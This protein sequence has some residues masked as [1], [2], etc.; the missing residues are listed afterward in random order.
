MTTMLEGFYS[1]C[2]LYSMLHKGR[3]KK[4][5]CKNSCKLFFLSKT[6]VLDRSGFFDM[7]I[8]KK[9]RK[10]STKKRGEGGDGS[11]PCGL[12]RNQ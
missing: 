8:E 4:I 5:K 11:E 1:M 3:R 2:Y 6:Y 12:V 7:H 9:Q 10:K